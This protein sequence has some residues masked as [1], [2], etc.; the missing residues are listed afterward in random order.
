MDSDRAW[1]DSSDVAE[2]TGFSVTTVRSWTRLKDRPLPV[3]YP[4]GNSERGW[5]VS[6]QEVDDW[7]RSTWETR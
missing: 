4:P 2:Y 6:R 7:I 3:H 5:R 1:L